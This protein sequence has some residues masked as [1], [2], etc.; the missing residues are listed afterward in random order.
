MEYLDYY[1]DSQILYNYNSDSPPFY[2]NFGMHSHDSYE[3]LYLISGDGEIV[4]EGNSYPLCEKTIYLIRPNEAHYI[5]L[6]NTMIYERK[7]I[8]FGSDLLLPVDSRCHLL[9][10]YQKRSIG[11]AN[12]YILE[13]IPKTIVDNAFYNISLYGEETYEKRLAI[14]SNLITILFEVNKLFE[15]HLKGK[16]P[17][18]KSPISDI[19]LYINDHICDD[20]CI[21]TICLKFFVTKTQLNTLFKEYTSTT[22][23]NYIMVKRMVIA[24][25]MLQRGEY[26]QEVAWKCGY[27]DYSAFYK[28]YKRHYGV[29]PTEEK[30]KL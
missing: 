6:N 11:A 15:H 27:K 28:A 3:L 19:L 16:E 23:W 14:I 20:I 26:A 9:K 22:A 4:I 10:P 21:D 30:V 25:S 7:V 8:H 24:K 17:E 13:G 12:H 1:K 29:S 5:R 2:E 18:E